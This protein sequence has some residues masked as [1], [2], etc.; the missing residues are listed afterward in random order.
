[1]FFEYWI[2]VVRKCFSVVYNYV[3]SYE[4]VTDAAWHITSKEYKIKERLLTEQNARKTGPK[5][6]KYR[7]LP[8]ARYATVCARTCLAMHLPFFRNLNL[9]NTMITRLRF[10]EFLHN[11][12]FY[13]FSSRFI[14]CR[15][16]CVAYFLLPVSSAQSSE[17]G[18]RYCASSA[19][20]GK[21]ARRTARL[22]RRPAAFLQLLRP[23]S[24]WPSIPHLPATLHFL[25][26]VLPLP[27]SLPAQSQR[28]HIAGCLQ[29]VLIPSSHSQPATFSFQVFDLFLHKWKFAECKFSKDYVPKLLVWVLWCITIPSIKSPVLELYSSIIWKLTVKKNK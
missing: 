3:F 20:E 18:D 26:S 2:G 29:Y 12:Y 23:A 4:W 14:P 19:R 9:G 21:L 17:P 15:K 7:V 1:M 22:S 13:F 10:Q 16:S 28:E 6:E 27:H 25:S 5:C 11:I 24:H 8:A